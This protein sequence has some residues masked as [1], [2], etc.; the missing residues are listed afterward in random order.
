MPEENKYF[1]R[2]SMTIPVFMYHAIYDSIETLDDADPF[3]AISTD[4]FEEQIKLCKKNNKLVGSISEVLRNSAPNQPSCIFTFDDGHISNF[5]AAKTLHKYGYT[6]DFFI[7]SSNI[8][9]KNFLDAD[10]LIEMVK[11][12]MSIQSHGHEHLY[13][14]D[15][16]K[17]DVYHQLLKSKRLIESVTGQ[18]VNVFAPPGG[19][20][21]S[22]VKN[23]ALKLNYEAIANSKPG[24]WDNASD[25]FN[26]P[27]LPILN[28][29]KL[30]EFEDWLNVKFTSIF[31]LYYK[32]QIKKIMKIFLGNNLYEKIRFFLLK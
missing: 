17:E 13:I 31:N 4:V 6:A 26:I 21:N 28:A 9:K 23:I 15:L 30:S 27:R 18:A 32:Y 12:G 20:I 2:N 19:R 8:G 29:T 1:G 7:N 3:Y 24:V 22:G 14:S 25:K 16:V 11:W 10:Q 5:K